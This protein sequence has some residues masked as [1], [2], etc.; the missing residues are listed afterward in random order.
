[1][2]NI[3]NEGLGKLQ[4][5]DSNT[6]L[7]NKNISLNTSYKAKKIQLDQDIKAYLEVNDYPWN[8]VYIEYKNLSDDLQ[9]KVK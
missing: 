5:S 9:H 6:I 7:S 3:I 4:W 8:I 1:M 2:N